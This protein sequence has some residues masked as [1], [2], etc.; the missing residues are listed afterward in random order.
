MLTFKSCDC[1]FRHDI[2]DRA[3]PNKSK[4]TAVNQRLIRQ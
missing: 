3:L 2:P 1:G 4:L